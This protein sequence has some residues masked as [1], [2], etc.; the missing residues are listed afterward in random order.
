[1][2]SFDAIPSRKDSASM[3]WTAMRAHN[4]HLPDDVVPF[5]AADMEFKN[6]PEILDAM[7]A[8][9]DSDNGVLAYY[10]WDERYSKAIQIWLRT[11][12][13]WEVST[14]WM[15]STAGILAGIYV[16]I[17]AYTKPG[18]GILIQSPVYDPYYAMIEGNGRRVITSDLVFNGTRYEMDFA[19]LEAKLKDPKTTMLLLCSP[20]NP[21]GRVWTPEELSRLGRLCVE[22]N[23][24]VVSD[25]AHCD[26]ILPGYR[27]TCYAS[28]SDEM[29]EHC[30]TFISPAK[31]FNLAGTQNACA[32][33]KNPEDRALFSKTAFPH[34]QFTCNPLSFI[35]VET[36]YSKCAGW[37][38]ELN[39]T[40]D[41][42]RIFMTEFINRYIPEI[43]V[44]PMEGTYLLW[45]DCRGLGMDYLELERFMKEKA[46]LYLDEGYM[47][48][49]AG[50]GFE[51]WNLACHVSI[52]EKALLRLKAAVEDWRKAQ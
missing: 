18:D 31:G 25:E 3:K 22:N 35:A 37:L 28:L 39:E 4:N 44:M 29:A 26:L 40:I 48:G 45:L 43:K 12:H 27:H 7:K 10:T 20:H 30:V 33:I 6:A 5:S 52:L 23:V 51:R 13:N 24:F 17:E 19:D 41:H 36:A 11:R 15:L 47:F 42:N 8:F 21:V 2:Y 46:Y 38:D 49:E 1:M 34:A 16:A 9:L 14:D 32:I 50:R